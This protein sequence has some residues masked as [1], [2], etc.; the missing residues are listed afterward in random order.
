MT[1]VCYHGRKYGKDKTVY[2]GN[3]DALVFPTYYHN[4]TFGL[5]NLEAMEHKLPVIATDEGGIPDV[6]KNGENGLLCK[7][8]DADSLASSIAIL[9]DDEKLRQAMGEDGYRKFKEN[10]TLQAFENKIVE[11]LQFGG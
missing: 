8:R 7:K 9:C 10:F 5:V 11:G 2:L 3:D 1:L 6:V 4:E